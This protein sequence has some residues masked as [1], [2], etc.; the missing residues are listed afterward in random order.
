MTKLEYLQ[1]NTPLLRS[2]RS[3]GLRVT[4]IDMVGVILM[5]E[6]LQGRGEKRVEAI[7]K[8]SEMSGYSIRTIYGAINRLKK[9]VL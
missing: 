5:V 2:M 6:S 7:R 3:N 1:Q 9:Q 8:T 4:D